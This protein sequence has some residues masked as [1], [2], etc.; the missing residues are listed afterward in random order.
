M[1]TTVGMVSLG[2]PKNLTDTEQMLGKLFQ[3]GYQLVGSDDDAEVLIVN[4]C[5]FLEESRS[6]A[7]ET[8]RHYEARKKMG[9]HKK[10][11]VTGCLPSK[12]QEKVLANFPLV[13]GIL[14]TNNVADIVKLVE[15]KEDRPAYLDSNWPETGLGSHDPLARMLTTPRHRAYLKISEGCNHTCAFCTIPT[16][17]GGHVSRS[18]EN[19]L[20][21][22]QTLAKAGVKEISLI[23]QDSTYYGLDL[24]KKFMLPQLLKELCGVN[25]LEWI[26][27]HYA[28]PDLVSDELI[29]ILKQQP[30]LCHYLDMPLQHI[31][32][33]ILVAMRRRSRGAKIRERLAVLQ[34]A[35]PDMAIR[36]T[37][38]VGFP[39]ENDTHFEELLQFVREAKFAR[40]G[41]F[42]YSREPGTP[43]AEMSNQVAE[44][45]KEER[46][47]RL[48]ETQR[49]ISKELNSQMIGRNVQVLVENRN[50]GRT[51][52]D[53]PDI[54]GTFIFD[55]TLP[56]GIKAGSLITARVTS[57]SDYDLKGVLVT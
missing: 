37:L 46:F 36:T 4:T 12:D 19:I 10:L 54:D 27:V 39:G 8:I 44:E 17:R 5:A 28:Y 13:D 31:S 43:S 56:A 11:I 50:S 30:K 42:K 1:K 29:D 9:K 47:H 45:V 2:C 16:I 51:Y 26:R 23:A 52:R 57:A 21:E 14:G 22:A 35:I 53:A 20:Q 38:I 48:M 15:S 49:T 41:A 7:A 32:D 3:S 40:L 18:I 34:K 6:E 25:G 33:D 55:S 24:Y